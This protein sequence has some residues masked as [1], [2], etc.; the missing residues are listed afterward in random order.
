MCSEDGPKYSQIDAGS[1][2]RLP[3]TPLETTE[4]MR[5]KLN[6]LKLER[7][8]PQTPSPQCDVPPR[9][10]SARS[11]PQRQCSVPRVVTTEEIMV[12]EERA[13]QRMEFFLN[14]LEGRAAMDEECTRFECIMKS[15]ARAAAPVIVAPLGEALA[16]PIIS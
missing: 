9:R 6:E 13:E 11:L 7:M 8:R 2:C 1:D 4:R 14:A 15:R 12:I 16:Q 5:A 3:A 10:R